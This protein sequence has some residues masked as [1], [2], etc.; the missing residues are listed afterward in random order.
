[1]SAAYAAAVNY[2]VIEILLANDVST[3]LFNGKPV[4]NSGPRSLP[5]NSPDCIILEICIFDKLSANY[6]HKPYINLCIS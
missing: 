5:R 4:L 3:F 6:L 2:N 1:M